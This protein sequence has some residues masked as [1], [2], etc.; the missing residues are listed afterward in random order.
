VVRREPPQA[1]SERG[2]VEVD[3]QAD[4]QLRKAQIGDDLRF[5]NREQPLDRL[6]LQE[7]MIWC[8]KLARLVST[9]TRKR[10]QRNFCRAVL[11]AC[12]S[13][14]ETGDRQQATGNRQ[15]GCGVR[16]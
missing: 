13:I 8:E 6:E 16:T 9:R 10:N 2:H 12:R 11:G 15:L 4:R 1:I 14:A 3:E 5:M 7:D